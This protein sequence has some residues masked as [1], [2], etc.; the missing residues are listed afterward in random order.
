MESSPPQNLPPSSPPSPHPREGL[1]LFLISFLLL[2]YELAVIRWIPASIRIVGYFSNLILVSCFFGFG[3]GCVLRR[4]RELFPLFPFLVLLT[5]LLCQHLMSAGVIDPEV[6]S[7]FFA[8]WGSYSWLLAVPIIFVVNS[9]PFVCIG[10]RVARHLDAFRPI[11]GY[12]INIAGSLAGTGVFAAMSFFNLGPV[13]WFALAFAT[14]LWFLR[15]HT[16]QLALGAALLVVC[17]WMVWIQASDSLWSPYY[18]IDVQP[19]EPTYT[20][21]QRIIVNHDYHQLLLDLSPRWI[22]AVPSLAAWQ[23]TYDFPYLVGGDRSPKS[24]LVLGA[25]AGNDVAAALRNGARRVVAVE[26]DPVIQ[27]LGVELHPEHPY[28]DQRVKVVINDARHFLRRGQGSFDLIILGWLD[29]HRLFSSLSNV[30]QD[31][32]VYTVEAFEQARTLLN[33]DGVLCVSFYAGKPWI[34]HKLFGML[35][36][37]FGRAPEVHSLDSGGYGPD[38]MIFTITKT[39]G[40]SLKMAPE[41]FSNRGDF[42]DADSQKLSLPT[43]NWPYLYYRG[44]TV[45]WEYLIVALAVVVLAGI[46]VCPVIVRG[47]IGLAQGLHFMFLGAGFLLLEVRNITQL[48][49]IFGS[50]WLTTSLVILAVLMMILLANLIVEKGLAA[51]RERLAWILLLLSIGLSLVWREDLVPIDS[52]A[53][54]GA[55]TTAVVSLT[56]LFAGIVFAQSFARVEAASVAL[57]F[58]VFGAVVGGMIEYASVLVGISG[59]TWIALVFYGLSF[60]AL[61]R[62]IGGWV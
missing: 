35:H 31:N 62:W 50:T 53:V 17:G 6:E 24:V 60:V 54:L 34:S 36:K 5:L 20:R 41:T 28:A 29:S 4:R 59:L 14:A 1:N 55:L 33:D 9:L 57:G 27:R 46:M 47:R 21:G 37:A 25:G 58:N 16:F 2:F 42:F 12:T 48:A 49:L 44:R 18:K 10:Q 26:L 56:F 61:R 32:F 43:D 15:G 39:A 8:S 40:R 22:T 52:V 51:G 30:R 45:A 11:P 19:L 38:G 13:W 3:L 7:Y 23:E